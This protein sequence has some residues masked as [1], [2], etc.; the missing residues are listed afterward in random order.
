MPRKP[1]SVYIIVESP[2]SVHMAAPGGPIAGLGLTNLQAWRVPLN[3][4]DTVEQAVERTYQQ[5]PIG[6][7][8]VAIED[9]KVTAYRV[10]LT[11]D[12]VDDPRLPQEE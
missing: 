11:L 2:T 1:S 6:S 8:V 10:G 5:H 3:D 9:S 7:T 4:G 12:E